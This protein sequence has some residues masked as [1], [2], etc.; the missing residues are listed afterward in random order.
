M[1][2]STLNKTEIR[3]LQTIAKQCHYE[4][5]YGVYSARV[6]LSTVD[7]EVYVD[8]CEGKA[9]S[10]LKLATGVDNSTG[11]NPIQIYPNPANDKLN[12]ALHLE[13]DQTGSI[14]IYDLT[15]KLML[16]SVLTG[17]NNSEVSTSLLSDGLYIY[18]VAINDSPVST[19]K[20]SIIR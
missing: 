3:K 19:G 17:S 20:L 8:N 14:F 9:K 16:T 7:N 11:S 13:A 2:Y 10:A 4:G 12:I 15:G 6:L 5:G 18:K 1:N